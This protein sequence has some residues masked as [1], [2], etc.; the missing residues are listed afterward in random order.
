MTQKQ[1]DDLS[2]ALEKAQYYQRLSLG[3]SID[4]GINL[5]KRDNYF[6]VGFYYNDD[7]DHLQSYIYTSD[8]RH[9]SVKDFVEKI[10]KSLTEM[11]VI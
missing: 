9:G 6:I 1:K 7:E 2:N 3:S 4:A 11:E 8:Y 10:R 5:L